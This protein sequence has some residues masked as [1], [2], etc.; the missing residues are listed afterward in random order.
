[1][2]N[3]SGQE[4]LALASITK[5]EKKHVCPETQLLF[6]SSN[7]NTMYLY[8]FKNLLLALQVRYLPNTKVSTILY[9]K[10]SPFW[11]VPFL[12]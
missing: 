9:L 7:G 5:R 4:F 3:L 1:M 6:Y 10:F 8:K 2:G 12:V 11:C